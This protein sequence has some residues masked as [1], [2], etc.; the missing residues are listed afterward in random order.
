[1]LQLRTTTGLSALALVLGIAGTAWLSTLNTGWHG[2]A[3]RLAVASHR[4]QPLHHRERSAPVPSSRI[5]SLHR[6]ERID[7]AAADAQAAVVAPVLVPLAMPAD[8]S[9][10]WDQLHGHLDGNVL[11]HVRVGAGGQVASASVARSSGDPIL[12]AH[13]WRSVMG[14]RFAVPADHPDGIEG[15]LPMHFSSGRRDALSRN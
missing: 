11:L 8:A 9:R 12:D 2:P 1:M 7:D 10:R 4:A 6:A 15:E 13:A 5:A 14:W 3:R